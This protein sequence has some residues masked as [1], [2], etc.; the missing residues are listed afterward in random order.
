MRPVAQ[1]LGASGETLEL[2]VTYGRILMIFSAVFVGFSFACEPLVSYQYGAR[3]M[4]EVSSLLQKGLTFC[5]VADAAM[6]VF[7]QVSAPVVA[8]IFVGYDSGLKALTEHGFRMYS[9]AFL[10]M[11][12]NVFAS[13]FFTALGNGKVSAIISLLRTFVFETGAVLL[14]PMIF[15]LDGVWMAVGVAEVVALVVSSCFLFAQRKVYG[16]TLSRQAVA[17]R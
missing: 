9:V 1:A 4:G 11:G 5:A 7:A 3:R 13:G 14:L 17:V 12:A 6:F 2:S 15:G 10:L 8:S 16:Y